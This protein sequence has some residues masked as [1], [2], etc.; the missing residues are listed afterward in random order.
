MALALPA[1]SHQT[2]SPL[3]STPSSESRLCEEL[4]SYPLTASWQKMIKLC[5][6]PRVRFSFFT[7]LHLFSVIDVN[8]KIPGYSL[9][10]FVY[11]RKKR[12]IHKTVFLK[13]YYRNKHS[14]KN[15]SLSCE[16]QTYYL[17]MSSFVNLCVSREVRGFSNK[18]W[19]QYQNL[20]SRNGGCFVLVLIIIECIY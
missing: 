18:K 3:I 20:G 19:F 2:S 15:D 7:P 1:R 8:S 14:G 13:Y 5:A 9:G 10:F 17:P 6:I 12:L 11:S 16:G 4:C